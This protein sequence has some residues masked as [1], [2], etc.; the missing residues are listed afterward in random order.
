VAYAK[1]KKQSIG[2]WIAQ[3]RKPM[4]ILLRKQT[5]D[6]ALETR[7]S[8]NFELINCQNQLQ[9]L[10]KE[11]EY[12]KNQENTD[13]Q[14]KSNVTEQLENQLESKHRQIRELKNEL[15][16]W[17]NFPKH[18]META[19]KAYLRSLIEEFRLKIFYKYIERS[20]M[21]PHIPTL[22]VEGYNS[23]QKPTYYR[24][25]W[26]IRP[27]INQMLR[28]LLDENIADG[29]DRMLIDFSS[30]AEHENKYKKPHT[31]FSEEIHKATKFE[32]TD[33]V[34]KTYLQISDDDKS[35]YRDM[36]RFVYNHDP[37]QN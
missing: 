23:T 5:E 37:Q 21:K 22:C 34:N 6:V 1:D 17:R 11:L 16:E 27:F 26:Q 20:E 19:Q 10:K 25:H 33:A 14:L 29:A 15:E 2:R 31:R 13:L 7:V 30:K 32:L 24:C 4:I 3:T 12:M 35:L 9:E 18:F 36:F 8:S 28:L